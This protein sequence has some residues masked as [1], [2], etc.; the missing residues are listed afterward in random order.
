[1]VDPTRSGHGHPAQPLEL[2]ETQDLQFVVPILSTSRA[3]QV[4]SAA[5]IRSAWTTASSAMHSLATFER[6][7]EN[8]AR[9][10]LTREAASPSKT[11]HLFP[12]LSVGAIAES[13]HRETQ[14][15]VGPRR[16]HHPIFGT[17]FS[18]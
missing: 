14:C 2:G 15:S 3:P 9:A 18:A 6:A 12:G 10:S 11:P 16:L 4:S 13:L 8:F 5:L 7:R 17:S 1:M